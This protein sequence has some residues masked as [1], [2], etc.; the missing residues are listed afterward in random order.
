MSSSLYDIIKNLAINLTCVVC[1]LKI[2]IIW[3][4]FPNIEIIMEIIRNQDKRIAKE[5]DELH[6][7]KYKVFK[8]LQLT[9]KMFSILYTSSW[10]FSETSVFINGLMGSWNLLFP[11]YFPFDPY[12]NVLQYIVAHIYQ[13]V[14]ITFQTL[15][16]FTNDT[17]L[18]MQLGLLSGQIHALGLRVS[19][20]GQIKNKLISDNKELLNCIRDHKELL[21]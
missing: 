9:F 8:N 14:G 4:K 1:S 7:Y 5:K 19:K 16:G 15:Q 21:K 10:I 12:A 11:A 13:F 6:Y 3:L 18:T 2:L 17:F 20:L